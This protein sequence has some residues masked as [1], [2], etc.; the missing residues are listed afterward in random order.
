MLTLCRRAIERH[1][2][3]LNC[4]VLGRQSRCRCRRCTPA[5]FAWL[6]LQ[7]GERIRT[8]AGPPR[9]VSRTD[10]GLFRLLGD[11]LEDAIRSC[12]YKRKPPPPLAVGTLVPDATGARGLALAVVA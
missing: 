5:K 4:D 2:R 11:H 7:R 10:H 6:G 8:V 1:R 12:R 3:H 9:P